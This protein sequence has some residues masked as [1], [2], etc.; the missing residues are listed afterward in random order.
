MLGVNTKA[1]C[2]KI[3]IFI[4]KTF[5]YLKGRDTERDRHLS[6]AGLFPTAKTGPEQSRGWELNPSLSHGFGDPTFYLSKK[7]SEAGF[8]RRT[9]TLIWGT[10]IPSSVLITMPNTRPQETFIFKVR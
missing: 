2:S 8:G 9:G 4:V 7:T 6:F 3:L 1:S 10:G 5:I